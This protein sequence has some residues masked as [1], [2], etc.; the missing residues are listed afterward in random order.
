M[1]V[2]DAQ[3]LAKR[4]RQ[5]VCGSIEVHG[6]LTCRRVHTH[7]LTKDEQLLA[8]LVGL[9][10]ATGK[11]LS[12]DHPNFDSDCIKWIH[13]SGV[14]IGLHNETKA[15]DEVVHQPT[16][17][18]MVKIQG[19]EEMKQTPKIYKQTTKNLKT[20]MRITQSTQVIKNNTVNLCCLCLKN[21]VTDVNQSQSKITQPATESLNIL[22]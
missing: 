4:E 16:I 17:V 15:G 19:F 7:W 10:D 12:R 11:P 6:G 1:S 3:E 8:D 5:A 18:F 13:Q 14:H 20:L 21:I 22:L 2:A 9:E